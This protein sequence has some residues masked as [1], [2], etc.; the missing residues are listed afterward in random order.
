MFEDGVCAATRQLF[1]TRCGPTGL[2][3][4]R[5]GIPCAG[6]SCGRCLR[7]RR[8]RIP[9]GFVGGEFFAV[10]EGGFGA[11]GA[12][13][14]GADV[15]GDDVDAHNFAGGQGDAGGEDAQ[16]GAEG[17]GFAGGCLLGVFG[18]ALRGEFD[19]VAPAGAG[20][21]HDG[22]LVGGG[23]V[24]EEGVFGVLDAADVAAQGLAADALELQSIGLFLLADGGGFGFLIGVGD[25]GLGALVLLVFEGLDFVF[26]VVAK[27][28]LEIGRELGEGDGG[29]AVGVAEADFVGVEPGDFDVGVGDALGG[30]ERGK[31]ERLGVEAEA[32][33]ESETECEGERKQ[34]AQDAALAWG[35]AAAGTLLRGLVG[36]GQHGWNGGGIAR[37]RLNEDSRWVGVAQGGV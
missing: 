36:G 16:G 26:G 3:C 20:G 32:Q 1:R 19:A 10:F 12:D 2:L 25:D 28:G 5:S 13:G 14:F 4:W 33:A 27:E 6:R 11:D 23:D 34:G 22:E 7:P 35:A 24:D 15:G 21:D 31:G 18:P 37:R 30:G 17:E 8:R 9:C 29:E